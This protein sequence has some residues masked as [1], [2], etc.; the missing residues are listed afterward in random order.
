MTSKG[1]RSR[2]RHGRP[3][4]AAPARKPAPPSNGALVTQAPAPPPVTD[5]PAV[6]P[7]RDPSLSAWSVSAWLM[8]A[9]TLW[10]AI[11]LWQ[12]IAVGDEIGPGGDSPR[13][14]LM[15]AVATM[16]A[17]ATAF[18]RLRSGSTG[19]VRGMLMVAAICGVFGVF[20]TVVSLVTMVLVR[21]QQRAAAAAAAAP[22]RGPARRG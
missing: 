5:A 20:S 9:S 3:G 18:W 2:K 19:H 15:A 4:V 1:T 14:L 16:I 7:D 13:L 21:R 17:S 11:V 12:L 6:K 10:S 8:F 22:A